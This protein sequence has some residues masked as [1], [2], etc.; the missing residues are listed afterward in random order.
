MRRQYKVDCTWT[1]ELAYVIG[2]ITSDGNLSPSGRHI[3]LTSKDI[4]MVET[5]R[6]L[7]RLSNKIGRK[8][9][10]GE[11][12]KKY[13]V[14][15]FGDI[16]FY[17]FLLEIGL[18][19]AK[20]KTLGE[21][22]IPKSFF[23]DFLRGCIDGDGNIGSYNHP[24]SSYIQIRLS[25]CSGSKK[26]LDWIL[27]VIKERYPVEG[28][29]FYHEKRRDVYS[30]SFGTRDSLRLFDEIYYADSVPALSRKRRAAKDL[31]RASGQIGIGAR[32]R[33][34]SRKR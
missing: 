31:I 3:S 11:F 8:A 20:S 10:G 15:Q 32:L 28:G 5:A 14:L 13:F 22:K 21:L 12:E 1:P 26:F 6:K 17:E 19:P 33:T 27:A 4:G 9:R 34:V 24:E 23:A 2:L 29:Y 16:N 30:L 7:L 25:L 18:T